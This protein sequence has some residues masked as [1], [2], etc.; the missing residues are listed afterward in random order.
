M[1][2][3][4]YSSLFYHR[5]HLVIHVT[6]LLIA[7]NFTTSA[8]IA[9]G[10]YE[11]LCPGKQQ[12]GCMLEA[13]IVKSQLSCF[14][15]CDTRSFCKSV[16]IKNDSLKKYICELNFC[17]ETDCQR[18]IFTA[19]DVKYYKKTGKSLIYWSLKNYVDLDKATLTIFF[20]P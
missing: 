7:S 16:N 2:I 11:Q 20:G 1:K 17:A 15:F 10:N 6:V 3:K 9:I 8:N 4:H 5:A 12:L 19:D 13:L 14:K 18:L